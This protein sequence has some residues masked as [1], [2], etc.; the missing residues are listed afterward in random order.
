MGVLFITAT[1]APILSIV[2]YGPVLNAPDDLANVSANE[3][4]VKIV[5]V[6]W[7]IGA[8]AIVGIPIMMF[9]ILSR[10]GVS[11]ENAFMRHNLIPGGFDDL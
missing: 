1:V 2:F 8:A 9:P 10:A 3:N 7:L 5:A 6:F 11:G 4:Q